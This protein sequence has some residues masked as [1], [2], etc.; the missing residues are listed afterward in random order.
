MIRGTRS[1]VITVLLAACL[2]LGVEAVASGS[3]LSAWEFARIALP[4]MALGAVLILAALLVGDGLAGR[5]HRGVWIVAP[6]LLALAWLHAQ[7]QAYRHE[8]LFPWDFLFLG[9]VL[10]LLPTLA[11]DRPWTAAALGAS[12]LALFVGLPLIW[13]RR[14]YRGV[15]LRARSRAWRLATALPVLVVGLWAFHPRH[16]WFYRD[17]LDLSPMTWHQPSHYRIMGFLLGFAYN[18]NSAL[19]VAPVGYGPHALPQP[20]HAVDVLIPDRLPDIVMVMNEAYWDPTRLPGVQFDA[21][22]M[23]TTRSLWSGTIFSPRFG[24]GTADVEFEAL[25]GLTYAL[26]PTGSV[27]YQQ[28][29]RRAMPALP[30]FLRS[31]GYRTLALHPYHAWF[32]NRQ[33]VYPMLGFDEF[34]SRSEL[35][36]L[37][38]RGQFVSDEALA[39]EIAR[40]VDASEAPVFIFAV[41]MENHG[42]YEPDRYPTP[43]VRVR[44]DLPPD[45][46]EGLR[47]FT[48]GVVGGDR[49]LR[50]LVEWASVRERHTI[51]VYFGDHLPYLG[52]DLA[53]YSHT[54]YIAPLARGGLL[55][56]PDLMAMRQTPLVVWSNRGGSSRDLG[57]LSPMFLPLVVLQQAGLS[58]PY[59]TGFLGEL[60]ARYRV[61][62]QRVL[63]GDDHTP[64]EGWSTSHSPLLRQ[65]ALLQYDMLFG[66][67]HARDAFFPPRTHASGH[68]ANRPHPPPRAHA[69]EMP[70]NRG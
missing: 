60:R 19:V 16:W 2:A 31:C 69:P 42:P 28:Y 44:A 66:A 4:Q 50:R 45:L 30:D 48:E 59:F 27:P 54:G 5:P 25:T 1:L 8:P 36:H 70:A 39:E 41:T 40:Q 15:R 62:D 67:R 23:P 37:A 3:V 13:F 22:P 65:L 21:D 17:L 53:T 34:Q 46:L 64:F 47:T 20:P 12:V 33:S 58:H 32:W 6:V 57:T 38:V 7:K 11:E 55:P 18:A 68:D 35:M 14:S 51:V 63:L 10:N 52:A 29:L 26:L 61:I 24:G 56:L 49:A 9:Q 43:T